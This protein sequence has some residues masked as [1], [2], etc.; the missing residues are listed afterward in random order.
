MLEDFISL[1]LFQQCQLIY[2]ITTGRHEGIWEEEEMVSL[3][4]ISLCCEEQVSQIS[5]SIISYPSPSLSS[6]SPPSLL[7]SS[8]LQQANIVVFN[9]SYLLDPKVAD[10]VSKDFSKNSVVVFDEAHNI[11]G[12]GWEGGGRG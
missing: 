4:P 5:P 8:Q 7:P 12:W 11:G 2:F 1:Q 9:Y 10:I 3:L 6:L